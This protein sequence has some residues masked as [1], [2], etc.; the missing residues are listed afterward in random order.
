[1]RGT[2]RASGHVTSTE[3]PGN[4]PYDDAPEGGPRASLRTKLSER[5]ERPVNSSGW[6]ESPAIVQV[7]DWVDSTEW[8][9][10]PL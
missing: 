7:V 4:S 8:S 5:P 1:V 3:T 9:D 10:Q 2:T 6:D